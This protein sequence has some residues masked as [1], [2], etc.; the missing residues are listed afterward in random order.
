MQQSGAHACMHSCM[1]ALPFLHF[2]STF[3]LRPLNFWFFQSTLLVYV[4][5]D[6]HSHMIPIP[7][8]P[9]GAKRSFSFTPECGTL[10]RAQVAALDQCCGW[11][12]CR[13]YC[14]AALWWPAAHFHFGNLPGSWPRWTDE[15][16][17]WTHKC[18]GP[19]TSKFG[20]LSPFDLRSST[21]LLNIVFLPPS[22]LRLLCEFS[23]VYVC[24][25]VCFCACVHSII[26]TA[27]LHCSAVRI[28]Q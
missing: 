27:P 19:M 1:H 9:K 22:P 16:R 4:I 21:K 13:C 23:R 15:E 14:V 7:L 10:M 6:T 8:G 17:R 20:L 12:A 11:S 18:G 24:V 2:L 25:Q 28:F 3:S 5:T 26:L